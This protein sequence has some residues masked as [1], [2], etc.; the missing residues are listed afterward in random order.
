MVRLSR[1]QLLKTSAIGATAALA[2]CT[3]LSA[4]R[5]VDTAWKMERR[6]AGQT[7]MNP[8]SQFPSD[9][10]TLEW[11]NE[12]GTEGPVT[13]TPVAT[14]Q[15]LITATGDGAVRSVSR[16]DGTQRWET[17]LDGSA[18]QA[19]PAVS[20]RGSV[21]A[22]TSE[23]RLY[24]LSADSGEEIWTYPP[25]QET[26]T[27]GG[28]TSSDASHPSI[29]GQFTASVV[30]Y[31]QYVL[32]VSSNPV[33][34]HVVDQQTGDEINTVSVAT[35]STLS[36][37]VV[38]DNYIVVTHA[39]GIV[40]IEMTNDLL[41]SFMQ[42]D[43]DV[44]PAWRESFFPG[45]L[46]AA[47]GSRLYVPTR[48]GEI[49]A[50][51]AEKFPSAADEE[52]PAELAGGAVSVQKPPEEAQLWTATS[53][54]YRYSGPL[55][56]DGPNVYLSTREKGHLVALDGD[57][58]TIKWVNPD[59]EYTS[60]PSASGGLVYAAQSGGRI[61][62]VDGLTGEA[63][64]AFTVG[65]PLSSDLIVAGDTIYATTVSST[66]DPPTDQDHSST[67]TGANF[68]PSTGEQKRVLAVSGDSSNQTFQ[69]AKE[70]KLTVARNIDA[71]S[72][73]AQLNDEQRAR[74]A[75]ELIEESYSND[76]ISVGMARGAISR[77]FWAE[78]LVEYFEL[79]LSYKITSSDFNWY[80]G[81]PNEEFDP[82]QVYGGAQ[83]SGKSLGHLIAG[84]LLQFLVDLILTLV[85][86]RV[87]K[88]MGGAADDV[89][90]NGRAADLADSVARKAENAVDETLDHHGLLKDWFPSNVANELTRLVELYSSII[91]TLKTS[92]PDA[93][94]EV[95]ERAADVGPISQGRAETLI[96]LL[97]ATYPSWDSQAAQAAQSEAGNWVNDP[98][99]TGSLAEAIN[100]LITQFI[101]WCSEPFMKL[102]ET[103]I[104]PESLPLHM[105][106]AQVDDV[107]NDQT[108]S[109]TIEQITSRDQADRIRRADWLP[110]SRQKALEQKNRSIKR[111]E[112]IMARTREAYELLNVTGDE[113]A[114]AYERIL[115]PAFAASNESE[116][117]SSGEAPDALIGTLSFLTD[118]VT[119]P[120]ESGTAGF[121]GLFIMYP[122]MS[123]TRKGAE[124]VMQGEL[125][126]G[127]SS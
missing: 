66:P 110:G 46:P 12:L 3:G 61:A 13:T 53:E 2:G 119:Q 87:A 121:L 7:G 26:E 79:I 123:Q 86:G 40:A 84:N 50:Y 63:I 105:R 68:S 54:N 122:L 59:A 49:R 18:I 28:G 17:E 38:V 6:D 114:S 44:S 96:S 103:G 56:I 99:G 118:T 104:E 32:V 100:Q 58:G 16:E 73:F 91:L 36:P 75:I 47:E 37:A 27:A 31:Q 89:A 120:F 14:T 71:G 22:A 80:G 112:T 21:F 42:D 55:S 74:E 25:T 98:S 29:S 5:P 10:Y 88:K 90:F 76:E 19:S 1:R 124:H 15:R 65:A 83:T 102:A 109:K 127:G 82:G 9:Q 108:L 70:A 30:L 51:D 33:Q 8:M 77:L 43:P 34:L 52:E 85:G 107:W 60:P 72:S 45:G 106:A 117:D 93:A 115:D 24:A 126:D 4:E 23:G 78:Q 64:S 11:T 69:T 95:I 48:G 111:T 57:S 125:I 101:N 113:W 97:E 20:E 39:T 116:G 67:V 62:C 94:G 92:G 41:D 35:G 81:G